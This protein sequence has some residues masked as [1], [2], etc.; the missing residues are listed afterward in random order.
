MLDGAGGN[1][2]LNLPFFEFFVWFVPEGVHKWLK[3][4]LF[5]KVFVFT[6]NLWYLPPKKSKIRTPNQIRIND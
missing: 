1:K 3:E 2:W 4:F 5:R 6:Q